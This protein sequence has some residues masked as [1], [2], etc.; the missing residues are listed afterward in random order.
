MKLNFKKIETLPTGKTVCDG[1]NLN[2]TKT[3]SNGVKW[4]FRYQRDDKS[5]EMGLGPPPSSPLIKPAIKH[6]KT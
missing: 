1:Q 2:F 3:N 6:S 4:S 5:C